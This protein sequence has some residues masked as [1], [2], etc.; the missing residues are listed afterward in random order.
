MTATVL[1]FA[2]A[3]L[4][5]VSGSW[6]IVTSAEGNFTVAMPVKPTLS[7]SRTI[8]DAG[9][10][11][12]LNIVGCDTASAAYIASCYQFPTAIAR[13]G[14][15]SY[16]NVSRDDIVKRYNGRVT[17]EKQIRLDSSIGRDLTI[18]AMERGVG[19]LTIRLRQYI[20]GKSIHAL[21]VV[22]AP[23]RELPDDVGRFFGSF[24]Y[25]TD[26]EAQAHA[27][28]PP[29]T[30]AGKALASWGTIVDPYEDSTFKLEGSSLHVTLPAKHK[31]MSGKGDPIG[32]PRALRDVEVEGNFVLTVKVV[33]EFKPDGKSTNPKAVPYN[34]GGLLV[35]ADSGNYVRLER[36]TIMRGGKLSTYANF[37]EYE[38]GG[39]AGAYSG[40]LGTGTAYLK[41]ERRG[42]RI[43]GS[44]S[45]DNVTWTQIRPVDVSWPA[46]VKVGVLVVNSNNAPLS[47]T[48][49]D[50]KIN[51]K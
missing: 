30:L 31:D 26:K 16:L 47:V 36:A 42:G 39:R 24:A 14:E 10:S 37:E 50:F 21:L 29:I 48:F 6:Q 23:N 25:G 43:M 8:N 11:F 33:G 22:S 46:K 15:M 20:R 5:Q 17:S 12:K 32:G 38:G 4:S 3:L 7:S 34:G 44:V 13:G 1:S 9:G 45:N 28:A 18:Q 2:L 40:A 35:W 49:E 27:S 51:G 19:V 41:V